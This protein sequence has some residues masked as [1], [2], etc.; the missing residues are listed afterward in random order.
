[1]PAAAMG[2]TAKEM[3]IEF[4]ESVLAD[5]PLPAKEIERQAVEACLLAEG[6]PVSDKTN[7]AGWRARCSGSSPINRKVRKAPA[8]TGHSRSIRRPKGRQA[9][10]K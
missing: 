2:P 6:K 8:G 7:P 3:W 1:M 5:G 4:L 10:S 9:P